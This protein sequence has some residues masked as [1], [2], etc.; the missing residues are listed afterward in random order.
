MKKVGGVKDARVRW[1]LEKSQYL[2]RELDL[3]LAG[4]HLVSHVPGKEFTHELLLI[5]SNC[6]III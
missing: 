1:F 3:I 2:P 6:L 4:I 5:I